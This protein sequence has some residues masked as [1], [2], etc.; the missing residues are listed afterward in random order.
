[1]NTASPNKRRAA[2]AALDANAM[3]STTPTSTKPQNTTPDAALL[4]RK[5]EVNSRRS[6]GLLASA[7]VLAPP[8]P[9]S[10]A[11][12][13]NMPSVGM[14]RASGV[15]MVLPDDPAEQETESPA[16]KKS[17]LDE[18]EDVTPA[19][20][21]MSSAAEERS[22]THSPDASSVFD[23]SGAEDATWVTTATEPD[24]LA[25]HAA[26]PSTVVV[27]RP[28]QTLTR[29]QAREVCFPPGPRIMQNNKERKC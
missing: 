25:M 18:Q 13:S 19:S 20:T 11:P 1:M 12:G 23:N 29:E 28:P 8:T 27:A 26:L 24:V 3:T 5:P 21:Q 4:P 7:P 10:S 22:R 9:A 17:K 14:K 16:A 2:L 6:F 15:G